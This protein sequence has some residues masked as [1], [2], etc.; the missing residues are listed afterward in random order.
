MPLNPKQATDLQMH[1]PVEDVHACTRVRARMLLLPR[2]SRVWA[3][4]GASAKPPTRSRNRGSRHVSAAVFRVRIGDATSPRSRVGNDLTSH[5]PRA[6]THARRS[7]CARACV[8]A[9][10][11]RWVWLAN[12]AARSSSRRTRRV[13]RRIGSEY[14][15]GEG[16]VRLRFHRSVLRPRRRKP[17]SHARTR[18]PAHLLMWLACN[19]PASCGTMAQIVRS[20]SV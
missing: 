1:M 7:S 17:D 8:R 9:C 4:T 20:P 2:R 13:H 5:L 6:T 19:K 14:G 12:L 10:C 11:F 15:H 18:V 16:Y 3:W